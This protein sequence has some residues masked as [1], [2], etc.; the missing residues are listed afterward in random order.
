MIQRNFNVRPSLGTTLII[1][2]V[3]AIFFYLMVKLAMFTISTLV[4]GVP[5]FFGIG[6]ILLAITY[7]TD[8]SIAL[9][10]FRDL[11]NTFKTAPLNAIL[12]SILT[13]FAAPFVF[14]F[15]LFKATLKKR[16][17]KTMGNAQGFPFG[18]GEQFNRQNEKS[19][20]GDYTEIR[21]DDG[22]VIRIP[23]D[24]D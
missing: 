17:E 6:L 14:G 9:N 4:N 21:Q 13:V 7:F 16:M 18:Q 23:K 2:A 19:I 1:L 15:L 10:Y 11:G 3:I 24:Q 5:F 22:L 20:G 8:K 12:K